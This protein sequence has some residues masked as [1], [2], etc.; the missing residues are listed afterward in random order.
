MQTGPDHL[1]EKLWTEGLS[2]GVSG[3]KIATSGRA[4]IYTGEVFAIVVCVPF[5]GT[6]HGS[7]LLAVCRGDVLVLELADNVPIIFSSQAT[8]KLER[9]HEK[10]DS[11]ARTG[12][13]P[14]RG[15]VP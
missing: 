13:H 10:D 7:I 15:D 14:S 8:E 4:L 3:G 12:K 2:L 5:R 6:A 1:L 9:H 11:N